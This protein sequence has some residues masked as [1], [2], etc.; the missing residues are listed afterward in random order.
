M[1]EIILDDTLQI[2]TDEDQE[3]IKKTSKETILEHANNKTEKY[4][5][6]TLDTDA[7]VYHTN[8]LNYMLACWKD[9]YGIVLDPTYLW[10]MVLSE[11]S[12]IIKKDPEKY[13][14]YF[15][16]SDD[17]KEISIYTDDITLID[18]TVLTKELKNLIL[19]DIETFLPA[20]TT[21][22]PNTNFAHSA[23]FC[24]AVS[25]FYEYSTYRCGI[26]KLKIAGTAED[27]KVFYTNIEKL[28][29]IFTT[30]E[31]ITWLN[32]IFIP[33]HEAYMWLLPHMIYE[34]HDPKFWEN[35]FK[36]RNC[37]SGHQLEINGWITD[38]FFTM[39][40]Y[41]NR[42][43]HNFNTHIAEVKYKNL[44]TG[45]NFKL[46]SGLF[47]CKAVGDYLVPSYGYVVNEIVE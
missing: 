45:R 18:V 40:E 41:D 32:K 21:A 39:N 13:R 47:Q 2:E 6:D 30:D 10:H 46:Y 44:D 43:P 22:T 42:M 8:Y 5:S 37:D 11:L 19:T 33:V 28:K 20:F 29:E 17:K 34:G 9:H 14:K 15:T 7:R 36:P 26:P 3:Y 1:R 4:I 24:D 16:N 38:F 35:M 31:Q 27:W 25:P 12:I 23:V